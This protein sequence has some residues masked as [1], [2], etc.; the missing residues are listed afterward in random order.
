MWVVRPSAAI[1]IASSSVSTWMTMLTTLVGSRAR[2]LN[3]TIAMNPN[4]NQ[5]TGGLHAAP[6][7]GGR[8]VAGFARTRSSQADNTI[9]KGASIMTRTSLVMTAVLAVS[10]LTERPAATTCA[11]SWM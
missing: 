4:A 5:G 3:S 2:E 6:D 7:D 8:C 10:M 1:A 11:T 9:R